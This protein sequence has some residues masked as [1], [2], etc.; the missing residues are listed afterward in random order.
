MFLK[1]A[2]ESALYRNSPISPAFET[3]QT[4]HYDELWNITSASNIIICS[5]A[6]HILD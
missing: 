5:G 1:V 4:I 2:E 6:H 3:W